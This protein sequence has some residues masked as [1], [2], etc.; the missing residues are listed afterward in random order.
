MTYADLENRKQQLIR[1]ALKGSSF[2]APSTAA[3]ITSLTS[4]AT[5]DLTPLDPDYDDLGWL[6]EEGIA[7]GRDV[8]TSNVTSFGSATPTRTDVTADTT[9][10]TVV[11]QETKLLTLGLAT[12]ADLAAIV[13][14]ATTGEVKIDKPDTPEQ[15]Y[16]R[17]LNIAVD[18]S[19]TGKEIYVARWL[20]RAKVTGYAAQ[21]YTGG[22]QALTWGVTLTGYKD[23][24][25]GYTESWI[26]GGPGW[27][28]LLTD[29][30]ITGYV[31]A[32]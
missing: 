30:G 27:Q 17:N 32:P 25:L 19:D 7:F 2:I 14:D 5:A 26:F 13:A 12:G 11:C 29:M 21:S 24:T 28:E 20:P 18:Y 16:Y 9:T 4:G 8:S 10:I 23:S 1:K 31:P 15:R 22:D 6:T 3:A